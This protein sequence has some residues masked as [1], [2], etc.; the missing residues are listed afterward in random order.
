MTAPGS[1]GQTRDLTDAQRALVVVAQ[2]HIGL[3][4]S[5]LEPLLAVCMPD[6]SIPV[7]VT[8]YSRVQLAVSRYDDLMCGELGPAAFLGARDVDDDA[9]ADDRLH[10]AAA[11]AWFEVTDTVLAAAPVPSTVD[12]HAEQIIAA[13]RPAE[14][15][16][17]VA[18]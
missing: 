16:E 6:V 15:A 11:L 3:S 17:R 1:P 7:R 8:R 5:D 13:L 9:S 4:V 18:A 14:R 12:E 10:A 2:F